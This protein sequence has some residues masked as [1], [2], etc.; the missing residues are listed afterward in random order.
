MALWASDE[1]PHWPGAD[2][3]ALLLNRRGGRL[4]VRGA[5]EHPGGHRQS[6]PAR[7]VYVSRGTVADETVDPWAV[8][9]AVV[10]LASACK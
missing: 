3:S 7:S 5:H 1:R 8:N 9:V 2:T 10:A 4:S 6:E